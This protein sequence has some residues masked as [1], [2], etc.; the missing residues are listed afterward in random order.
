ME[1]SAGSFFIIVEDYAEKKTK[2]VLRRPQSPLSRDIRGDFFY[3]LM[4]TLGEGI[5]VIVLFPF[6]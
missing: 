1:T 4:D 2:F 3:F 5:K 6:C